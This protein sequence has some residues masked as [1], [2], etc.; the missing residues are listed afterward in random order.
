M[1]GISNS[2]LSTLAFT[3]YLSPYYYIAMNNPNLFKKLFFFLLF[4]SLIMSGEKVY[5]TETPVLSRYVLVSVAP[6]KFFIE[7]IADSTVQIGLMVP[8]GASAHTYEP[9]P[10]QML[11]A[12][13]ADLWMYVGEGFEPKVRAAL[14]S[15][16]PRMQFIDLRQHLDLISYEDGHRGCSHQHEGCYDLHYWLSPKQAKIQAETIADALI[17]LYPEHT[18]LYKT[19]LDKFKTELDQLDHEIRD[20]LSK[21]H[22]PVI[23]VSHPAY[24]YFCRDYGCRQLSIEFEG[25]DPTP[26]QLTRVIN[27]AR[28][29]NIKTIFVQVQYS[30][31]GARLI[32]AQIGAKVVDLDPYSEHYFDSLHTIAKAFAEN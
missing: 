23:M 19:N 30:S 14:H 2:E 6:H 28:L 8:A 20:I 10:K 24:A 32:A 18:Q 13:K 5:S 16:N 29:N 4:L 3:V 9:T 26:Q 7:K 17:K 25:K 15:Y 11:D 1:Q 27:A 12:T 22:N 31:K 21:P